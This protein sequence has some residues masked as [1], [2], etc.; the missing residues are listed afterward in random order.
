MR[1]KRSRAWPAP[2]GVDADISA[3]GRTREAVRLCVLPGLPWFG[4][5]LASLRAAGVPVRP[6]SCAR[7]GLRSIMWERAMRAKKS[8][9]WP[10]P[11]GVD[12]DISAVGRTREAVRLCVLPGLPWFGG[13]LAS[14]RAAGVPVRPTSCARPGQQSIMWERAMRAK[15][16]RAWPAPT[17]IALTVASPTVTSTQR[18]AHSTP[19]SARGKNPRTA[20]PAWSVGRVS[21]APPPAPRWPPAR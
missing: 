12:A 8:R 17:E 1:A 4:G 21:G 6:T 9:A 14:L 15:K 11:T 20:A 3:V 2:T 18:P 5:L 7:P 10:A 13:L 16:S 19:P